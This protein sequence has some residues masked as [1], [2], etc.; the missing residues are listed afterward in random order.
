M[1]HTALIIIDVQND[2]FEGGNMVLHQPDF[3][4]QQAKALL[5]TWRKKHWPIIHIQHEA[6][7]PDMPFMQPGTEGQRIHSSVLPQENEIVITKHYPNAYWET[8]LHET[9]QSLDIKELLL[10]GMMAHMC[11]SATARAGMERGYSIMIAQ[12]ACATTALPYGDKTIDAST[13]HETA[14][15]E[16]A[17]FS[18]IT[19]VD[20]ILTAQTR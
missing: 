4:A 20:K 10:C 3:A 16:V 6:T 11:V 9:L 7:N 13:V 19:T 17:Y 1:S 12:D 5:S 2:Y 8:T 18:D 15:A 14:L